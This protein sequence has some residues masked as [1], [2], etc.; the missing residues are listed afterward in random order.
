MFTYVNKNNEYF[1]SIVLT[2]YGSK[3]EYAYDS[4]TE[5]R[6]NESN[7]ISIYSNKIV[8]SNPLLN[9]E[10]DYTGICYGTFDTNGI[11]I[12]D[13]NLYGRTVSMSNDDFFATADPYTN[14][15]GTTY[16]YNLTDISNPT[17][18]GTNDGDPDGD[19]YSISTYGNKILY[20]CN[21]VR[22]YSSGEFMR[23]Y[24]MAGLHYYDGSSFSEPV[25]SVDNTL[26]SDNIWSG[27]G[28]SV[29]LYDNIAVVSDT[30]NIYYYTISG[31]SFFED[32]SKQITSSYDYSADFGHCI[33]L[34]GSI[35]IIGIPG[36][37]T[38]LIYNYD[39]DSELELSGNDNSKFGYSVAIER[40]ILSTR[41]V[42]IGAPDENRLYIYNVDGTLLFVQ[43][44]DADDT[45]F[46]R[47]VSIHKGNIAVRSDNGA[48]VF[49][50]EE[51][52]MP[53]IIG[54]PYIKPMYGSLYKLPDEEAFYRII[55]GEN[56][57]INAQVQKVEQSYINERAKTLN[58][59]HFENVHSAV[60]NW[61]SM[62]FFTQI[63]I[64]Y[65][66][67][68]A[69]YDLLKAN[70]IGECP[71][72]LNLKELSESSQSSFMY[73]NEHVL[74][75]VELSIAEIL[76]IQVALYINPQVLTGIKVKK[77]SDKLDGLLIYKYA[78]ASA[79]VISLYD[80]CK[81]N[82]TKADPRFVNE[83]FFSNDGTYV[84]RNIE[85]V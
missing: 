29:S 4:N 8:I 81:C 12:T 28:R 64:H 26:N 79:R 3:Y 62:Y 2:Q 16:K 33:S 34:S 52:E 19:G 68:I 83:T 9:N 74:K 51:I 78:S 72:W 13:T 60:Y 37:N 82:Y 35:I 65:K 49:G 75:L 59:C 55:E 73:Q 57:I 10:D 70:L 53:E 40:D 45:N 25:T 36:N 11:N 6:A 46:G 71:A 69:M 44:G 85:I 84:T 31:S 48:Y 50:I 58:S 61:D 54:D 63:C 20:G 7:T 23:G 41:Y 24:G 15:K 30:T 27:Y 80:M 18:L 17:T 39:D 22:Y 76:T 77:Y 21:R 66:D 42:V 56:V 14:L 67:E 38:V 5:L 32:N 1:M 47:S 43:D